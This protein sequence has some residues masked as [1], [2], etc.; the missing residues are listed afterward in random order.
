M[1]S[2][3]PIYLTLVILASLTLVQ[4]TTTNILEC[5]SVPKLTIRQH[6]GRCNNL[7][8]PEWGS[9]GQVLDHSVEGV[10]K[11]HPTD[12]PNERTISNKL[13]AEVPSKLPAFFTTEERRFG[14]TPD[15]H[16]RNM[17]FSIYG[18]FLGHDMS[19]S[20]GSFDPVNFMNNFPIEIEDPN[21]PLYEPPSRVHMLSFPSNVDPV[22]GA[23]INAGTS[24][25]D[26]HT[27]YG[28]SDEVS[29]KLRAFTGGK[30]LLRA[31]GE[32]PDSP[33]L[34]L[35]NACGSGSQSAAG[36]P[37]VDENPILYTI[38]MIWLREHNRKCDELASANPF[39]NDEQLYQAA[40]KWVIALI[41]H[42]AYNEFFPTLLGASSMAS[43][44][45][46][47]SGYNILKNP[48]LFNVFASAVDRIPHDIANLPLLFIKY[49]E[50]TNTCTYPHG[51]PLENYENRT[52]LARCIRD[53][54]ID[55]G[56]ENIVRSSI[57]QHAQKFD[58][59]I[60]DGLRV[61]FSGPVPAAFPGNFDIETMVTRRGRDHHLPDFNTLRQKFGFGSYYDRPGCHNHP[62]EDTLKCF[63]YITSDTAVA[64]QLKAFYH[65][66]NRV[67]SYVGMIIEEERTESGYPVTASKVFF[68]Q[69][70]RVRDG[71]R[72]WFEGAFGYSGAELA[73]IK[74]TTIAD[75]IKR[76]TGVNVPDNAF[77]AA[78]T[79]EE[80]DNIGS[81]LTN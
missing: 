31:D 70:K 27:V 39:L 8:T 7:L 65:K 80:L 59:R 34:G 48:S 16:Q 56:V 2:P 77:L 14:V 47:Y 81:C 17:F 42:T 46:A 66:V 51:V 41:Q 53:Y 1:K 10:W 64:Q 18:Q 36:D 4:A 5:L 32:F 72:F 43:H 74:A 62:T 33:P 50:E 26:A 40:R 67:E 58:H 30:L 23:G 61:A 63:L 28:W 79:Q 37:R 13:F 75:V 35:P 3:V 12:F 24:F 73:A 45:G 54:A 6:D 57:V 71:D 44:V 20:D 76:N 21:D 60:T 29:N 69:L 49:D 55:V 68:E 78:N 38:H 9:T 11:P 52:I 19:K 22:S 25:I 15:P